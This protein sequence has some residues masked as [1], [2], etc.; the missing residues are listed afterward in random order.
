MISPPL[1][2]KVHLH[3]NRAAGDCVPDAKPNRR[4][5]VRVA[6]CSTLFGPVAGR[7]PVVDDTMHL[8]SSHALAVLGQLPEYCHTGGCGLGPGDKGIGLDL[9]RRLHGGTG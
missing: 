6:D 2:D 9:R 1:L 7:R 8:R 3:L 4:P 5:A